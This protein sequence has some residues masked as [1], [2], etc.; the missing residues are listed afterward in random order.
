MT[1][2]EY[3]PARAEA[4]RNLEIPEIT[5]PVHIKVLWVSIID[6][7][8]SS[9]YL[10]VHSHSFFEIHFVFSGEVTYEHAG[11]ISVLRKGDT[12]FIPPNSMHRFVKYSDHFLKCSL[13]FRVEQASAFSS[14]FSAFGCKTFC[15]PP[16][17]SNHIN[18][19]LSQSTATDF[20]SPFLIGNRILEIIYSLCKDFDVNLP[21]HPTTVT[22]T[23]FTIAVQYIKNNLH[24]LISCEDIAKEVCLSRKHLS[25]LFK[26][27][28]GKSLNEYLISQRSEYA[29]RLVLQNEYSIKQ[30]SFMLGFQNECSFISFF[31]QHF[32]V[33]PGA[34]RAQKLS[35]GSNNHC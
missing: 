24:R 9:I 16:H 17:I 25:R 34:Y 1:I 15:F 13:A 19:I 22:D 5:L 10:D 27:Y 12:L 6:S 8:D 30:I 7:Y 11:K 33:S 29:N 35:D 14:C 32:G 28:T 21:E 31:K 2:T 4:L 20:F 18:F 23:R 26:K 3:T